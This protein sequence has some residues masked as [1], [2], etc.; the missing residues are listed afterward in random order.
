MHYVHQ[1]LPPAKQGHLSCGSDL[2]LLGCDSAGASF[3]SLASFANLTLPLGMS[4]VVP[5]IVVERR[6]QLALR[7]GKAKSS[8]VTHPAAVSRRL[9]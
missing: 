7:A 2:P 9:R 3:A 6:M 1:F 5:L 4:E 8:N